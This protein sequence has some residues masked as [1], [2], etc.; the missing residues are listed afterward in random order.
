MKNLLN[1]A[2][3]AAKHTAL[4]EMWNRVRLHR[5]LAAW[6]RTGRGVPVPHLIKQRTVREYAARYGTPRL[7]ETG[8]Y[9]GTMLAA[10]RTQFVS[11]DSI[12]LDPYL[13]TRAQRRFR[14]HRDVRI[15]AG[16]SGAVLPRVL[17]A[18]TQPA[19]FWLDAHYSGGITARGAVDTPVAQEL[20]AILRHPQ[21]AAHV[22]L[23]DDARLF[24]GSEDYPE[25]AALPEL[26]RANGSAHQLSVSQDIIRICPS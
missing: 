12:E 15:H 16:D 17:E 2:V 22:I 25:L 19:L 23:I 14:R 10:V 11:S 1:V 9:M 7:V 4:Y 8:T 20:R 6:E 24:N 3:A 18:L 13:A 21:A 26:L 5:E